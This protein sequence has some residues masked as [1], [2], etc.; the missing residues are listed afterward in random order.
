[1]RTSTTPVIASCAS[2]STRHVNTLE[3]QFFLSLFSAGQ[4]IHLSVTNGK[5]GGTLGINLDPVLF[6][7]G[8]IITFKYCL[9]RTFRDTG[10]AV[11]ADIRVYIQH[12]IV[13][14]KAG[15]WAYRYAISKA[16]T[17]AVIGYYGCHVFLRTSNDDLDFFM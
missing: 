14:M 1:M 7:I 17:L 6:I 10:A 13:I 3:S 12:F 9:D 4:G 8:D 5:L 15:N 2:R 11:Y 16:A